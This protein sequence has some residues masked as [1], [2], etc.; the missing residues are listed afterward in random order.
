[1]ERSRWASLKIS[2]GSEK[3]Y[4]VVLWRKIVPSNEDSNCK[5]RSVSVI[6]KKEQAVKV[7]IGEA[8]EMRLA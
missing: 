7:A 1:L 8:W 4:H 5:G 6:S 2:E 3:T